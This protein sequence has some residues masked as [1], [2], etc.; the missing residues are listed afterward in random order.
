MS[1]ALSL[2]MRG[3]SFVYYGE[4]LGMEGSGKDE[5]K[6]APMYWS[7][8]AN[9]PG[10]CAAPA[11]MDTLQMRF[12]SLETQMTDEN[13]LWAWFKEV[14]HVRKAFPAIARGT[15]EA[16]DGVI[17]TNVA[18]FIRRS[19]EDQDVLV[20]MNLRDQAVE[21]DLSVVS[22]DLMLA[23]VLTTGEEG[24]SYENGVVRLPAYSIAV[25]T[26]PGA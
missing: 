21:K 20:V 19:A 26:I 18:A 8:D 6:R 14:I 16:V 1:Y 11:G 24:I 23:A 17:D 9:A 10:M 15:T 7:D 4:E 12:P 25:L 13:S 2:F 5:N 22:G 3:D